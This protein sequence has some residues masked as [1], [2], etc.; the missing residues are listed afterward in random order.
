MSEDTA[1]LIEYNLDIINSMK[2]CINDKDVS[3]VR[4][5]INSV[6]ISEKGTGSSCFYFVAKLKAYFD[7]FSIKDYKIYLGSAFF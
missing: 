6:K 1:E 7:Y 3:G 5:L 4:K 2:Q